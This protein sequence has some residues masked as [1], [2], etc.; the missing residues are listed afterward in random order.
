MFSVFSPKNAEAQY[1]TKKFMDFT[2]TDKKQQKN[3]TYD[4]L[5][6]LKPS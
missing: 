6:F 4:L 2:E 5:N 3:M 1:L